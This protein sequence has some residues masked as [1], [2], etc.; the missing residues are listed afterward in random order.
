M[1]KLEKY[2]KEL[3][4]L[5]YDIKL[6]QAFMVYLERHYPEES[7]GYFMEYEERSVMQSKCKK[8]G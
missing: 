1:F 7:E 5:D 6:R 2:P 4:K 8:G 3:N